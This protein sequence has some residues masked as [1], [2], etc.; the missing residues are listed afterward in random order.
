MVKIPVAR[1]WLRIPRPWII[2]PTPRGSSPPLPPSLGECCTYGVFDGGEELGVVDGVGQVGA[3]DVEAQ[4]FGR[5]VRHLHAVLQD[6]HRKFVRRVT[7][8]PQPEV[9]VARVR[10]QLLNERMNKWMNERTNELM[11]KQMNEW[12][13]ERKKTNKRLN[14][15]RNQWTNKWTNEW[16]N[17]RVNEWMN[18]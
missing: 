9:R 13:N 2:V 5:F 6:R 14:E 3:D 8:Q 10:V 11:N 7:R 4:T 1:V 12:T 15:W 17:E 18:E 16:M